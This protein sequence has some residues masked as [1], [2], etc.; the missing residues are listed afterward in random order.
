MLSSTVR[1]SA[2]AQFFLV[3]K[4]RQG[5]PRFLSGGGIAALLESNFS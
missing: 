4:L 2:A 5:D 1:S 3:I